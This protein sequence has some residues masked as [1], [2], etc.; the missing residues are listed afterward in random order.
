MHQEKVSDPRWRA[1]TRLPV[2]V[3]GPSIPR[4]SRPHWNRSSDRRHRLPSYGAEPIAGIA[5]CYDTEHMTLCIGAL[6]RDSS[7][8]ANSI[9]LCF[10]S[11]VAASEFGSETE[12]KFYVLSLGYHLKTG[13]T[14]SLPLPSLQRCQ[15]PTVGGYS[16]QCVSGRHQIEADNGKKRSL[17][18]T[19]PPSESP[20]VSHYA[21]ARDTLTPLWKI[22]RNASYDLVVLCLRSVRLR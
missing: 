15:N 5:D 22:A 20:P 16:K 17:L 18:L 7:M 10:D 4:P 6:C 19:K 8:S 3:C 2:C 21:V 1:K 12:Y 9:V 13:H 11:K 14:L